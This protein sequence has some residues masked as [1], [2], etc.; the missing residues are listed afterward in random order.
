LL[1]LHKA[2][3]DKTG[4]YY[5][6][7]HKL[8]L[9]YLFGEF[10]RA[11]ENATQTQQYLE[12]V[13]GQMA[14][15]LFHFYDSLV[16]LAVCPATQKCKQKQLFL[17]VKTN[18]KKLKKWAENAPMNF[19][20]KYD[21]VEA[22]KARVLGRFFVA[23]D[24]YEQAIKGARDNEYI[25]EEAL[26]Y[27]LAAKFYLARGREKFAQ[28]YM[29]EA[30]YCYGRWGAKAKVA[31]LEAKYPQLLTH[32]ATV[33]RVIDTGKTNPTTTTGNRSGSSLDLATMMKASQAISSEIVLDK[34]LA[35]LMKILIENA[36]AQKGFLILETQDRL[37]IEASGTVEQEQV[38]VLQS[39]PIDQEDVSTA[40]ANYVTRTKKSV[41]LQDASRE[42]KFTNDPYIQAHRPKSILCAPLI[43]QGK[44][45][46]IVYLENNL[47]TGAFTPD[48][49]EIVKLL[50]S[51]AAISIENAKLYA[52]VRANE[53]RLTQ[54][55]EAIPVGVTILDA[56]GKPSYVNLVAQQLLGKGVIPS[57]TTEQLPE[58]YQLHRA[59]T[60]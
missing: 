50:S 22:E 58:V 34:L 43:Y 55:L 18:Q 15:P 30:H 4:L 40:I 48:R 53:S 36:G 19:Q 33:T 24:L 45:V 35:S 23:E 11:V 39:I 16:H 3:N 7:I 42:G 60:N 8:I 26:A 27:E 46:S 54:F 52:E 28:T 2:A 13:T 20:H 56:N 59:G 21:L 17:H 38:A 51:Q 14:V 32:S 5:C 41:V 9:C 37:L 31:D 47:T 29:K 6:Y 12:G 25:Q 44:L 57:A 10:D 49:L 1:P